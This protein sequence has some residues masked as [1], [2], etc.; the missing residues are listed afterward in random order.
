MTR[1]LRYDDA[2]INILKEK[3]HD[4]FLNIFTLKV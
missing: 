1:P 4:K 2:F 3:M